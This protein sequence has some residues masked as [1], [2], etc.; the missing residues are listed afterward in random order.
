MYGAAKCDANYALARLGSGRR[1]PERSQW[2]FM[3]TS[4][5]KGEHSESQPSAL[6]FGM[7]PKLPLAGANDSLFGELFSPLSSSLSLVSSR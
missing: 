4:A 1:G 5:H 7:D 3:I 2:R 6:H